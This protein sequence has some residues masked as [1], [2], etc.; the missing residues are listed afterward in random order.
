MKKAR[1]RP[2]LFYVIVGARDSD[3]AHCFQGYIVD[4]STLTLPG[5]FSAR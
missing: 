5:D 4:V 2:R 3:R 1:L